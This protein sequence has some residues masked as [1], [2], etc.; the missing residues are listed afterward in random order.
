[1][2]TIKPLTDRPSGA[3]LLTLLRKLAYNTPEA[4]VTLTHL[5]AQWSAERF[6]PDWLAKIGVEALPSSKPGETPLTVA[7][8]DF[9]RLC[10]S[11][12]LFEALGLRVQVEGKPDFVLRV[13]DPD[14][15]QLDGPPEAEAV[16]KE[17]GCLG[18]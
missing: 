8:E 11:A 1:M 12:H 5:E 7:V 6:D 16:L 4:L 18:E 9:K 2:L 14:V 3:L 10:Q 13:Q 15:W 17:M